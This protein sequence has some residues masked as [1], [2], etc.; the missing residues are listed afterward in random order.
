[1]KVFL[2]GATGFIGSR[3]LDRLL[4]AGHEVIALVRKPDAADRL[5]A[6]GVSCV[7]GDLTSLDVIAQSAEKA[8]AALHLAFIHDFNEYESAC[9]TDS[10]VSDAINSVFAGVPHKSV[11]FLLQ[12]QPSPQLFLLVSA[13]LLATRTDI[14]TSSKISSPL[15]QSTTAASSFT[16]PLGLVLKPSIASICACMT[17]IALSS[18]WVTAGTGKPYVATSGSALC[19]DTGGLPAKEGQASHGPRSECEKDALKVWPTAIC[20]SALL[21]LSLDQQHPCLFVQHGSRQLSILKPLHAHARS[22]LVLYKTFPQSHQ[23][24]PA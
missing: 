7:L 23:D 24:H 20:I 10:A 6:R 16:R 17:V 8:D 18:I 22:A 11:L 19:G 1:M 2:T 5:K 4:Q 9:K 3:V 12:T 15:T 13:V 14:H 21:A